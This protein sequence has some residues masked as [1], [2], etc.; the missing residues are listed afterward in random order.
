MLTL[1]FKL[2]NII[3]FPE[4]SLT[5]DVRYDLALDDFLLLLHRMFEKFQLAM[6]CQNSK[7]KA[8]PVLSLGPEEAF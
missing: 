3:L 1:N 5:F 4:H 8:E 6:D 7:Y 2:K